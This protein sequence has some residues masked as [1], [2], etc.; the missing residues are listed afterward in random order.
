MNDVEKIK[1]RLTELYQKKD[2]STFVSELE[3]ITIPKE[4]QN[5]YTTWL[6]DSFGGEQDKW[7]EYYDSLTD[8]QRKR[9]HWLSS[10]EREKEYLLS[11]PEEDMTEQN[12]N[13]LKSCDF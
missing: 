4:F 7:D 9:L 8:E 12:W 13:D 11:L 1:K 2:M 10:S 5:V 6:N 3:S